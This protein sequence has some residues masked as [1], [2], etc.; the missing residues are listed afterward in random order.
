MGGLYHGQDDRIAKDKVNHS[1]RK[2]DC[3]AGKSF[4]HLMETR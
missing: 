3:D 4:V 1:F 2:P